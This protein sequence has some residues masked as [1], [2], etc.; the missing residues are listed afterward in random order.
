MN[1]T[2]NF[3]AWWLLIPSA[4]LGALAWCAWRWHW[5]LL[6]I[7]AAST[8][9]LAIVAGTLWYASWSTNYSAEIIWDHPPSDGTDRQR[10][11]WARSNHGGIQFF[12][13]N[14]YWAK[15]AYRMPLPA[16]VRIAISGTKPHYP[17]TGRSL[18]LTPWDFVEKTLG[19]QIAGSLHSQPTKPHTV[20]PLQRV[21]ITVPHWSILLL[22]LPFPLIWLRRHRRQRHR[23]RH[24]LCLTC[25]Y[26]LRSTPEKCPECGTV[27][28]PRAPASATT[29][30]PPATA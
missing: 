10:T 17:L 19:F 24:G 20:E 13:G 12:F 23:S 29:P 15:P 18:S 26:D 2:F 9:L 22:C 25:G 11:L 3:S 6:P 5:R 4:L 16:T 7:A 8:L 14:L 27:P 1:T 30:T 21:F 28:P